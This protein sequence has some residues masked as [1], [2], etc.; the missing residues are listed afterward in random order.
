VECRDTTQHSPYV[1]TTTC[2][3]RAATQLAVEYK[4]TTQRFPYVAVANYIRRAEILFANKT[5]LRNSYAAARNWRHACVIKK[6]VAEL[7]TIGGDE[8]QDHPLGEFV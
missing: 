5:C 1:A 8:A 7:Y 3:Q 4:D 6:H 2:N